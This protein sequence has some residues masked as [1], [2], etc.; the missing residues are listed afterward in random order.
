MKDMAEFYEQLAL[1][2]WPSLA[3][4]SAQDFLTLWNWHNPLTRQYPLQVG[5]TKVCVSNAHPVDYTTED[6]FGWKKAE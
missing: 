3:K 6:L 5:A 4:V 1:A 2:G